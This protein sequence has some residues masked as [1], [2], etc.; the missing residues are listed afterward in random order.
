M[1]KKKKPVSFDQE[2][3]FA[4]TDLKKWLEYHLPFS[5]A[6]SNSLVAPSLVGWARS[7][8]TEGCFE[9]TGKSIEDWIQVARIW[10]MIYAVNGKGRIL[11]LGSGEGWPAIPLGLRGKTVVGIDRIGKLVEKAISNADSLDAKN[12]NFLQMNAENLEFNN[13]TFDSVIAFNSVDFFSDLIAAFQES[14]RILTHG[15]KILIFSESFFKNGTKA[16][17]FEFRLHEQESKIHLSFSFMNSN[18]DFENFSIVLSEMDSSWS[19]FR[20]IWKK[21]RNVLTAQE[22][23]LLQNGLK[24]FQDKGCQCLFQKRNSLSSKKVK[25]ALEKAGFKKTKVVK[26]VERLTRLFLSQHDLE[27]PGHPFLHKPIFEAI[28]SSLGFLAIESEIDP[29]VEEGWVIGEKE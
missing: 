20:E 25:K 8:C 9:K 17:P 26:D 12:V 28:C 27:I 24:K 6:E 1:E 11:D 15:G 3:T 4:P 10:E 16:N 7:S 18:E 22:I 23:F 29:S 21:G 19:G 14:W 2:K 13:R 5:T